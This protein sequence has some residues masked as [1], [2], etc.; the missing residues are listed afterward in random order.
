MC[1]QLPQAHPRSRR[2]PRLVDNGSF[3]VVRLQTK[4]GG[5][6]RSTAD[7][8][9]VSPAVAAAAVAVAASAANAAATVV[10]GCGNPGGGSAFR[11]GA[12]GGGDAAGVVGGQ[13]GGGVAETGAA[14]GKGATGGLEGAEGDGADDR[15]ILMMHEVCAHVTRICIGCLSASIP[16]RVRCHERLETYELFS[17]STC[18]RSS[19]VCD[20]KTAGSV[21]PLCFSSASW[22]A[23]PRFGV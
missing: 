23:S 21:C 10:E 8:N 6:V 19:P 14:G 15:W 3:L 22:H 16:T 9:V 5:F 18:V 4:K 11:C 20:K 17:D 12:G 7:G 13:G 1:R 2:S